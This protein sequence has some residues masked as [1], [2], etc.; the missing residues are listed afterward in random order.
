MKADFPVPLKSDPV[1]QAG[2]RILAPAGIDAAR[3]QL[4]RCAQ[5]T[6][7]PEG[8]MA[9]DPLDAGRGVSGRNHTRQGPL[10]AARTT[11]AP[12][13]YPKLTGNRCQCTACGEY[14]NGLTGFDCHRIGEHGVDHRC[15]T[16]AEMTGKGW[17]KSSASFW[18]TDSHAQRAARQPAAGVQGAR[19]VDPLPTPYPNREGA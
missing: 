15:M 2:A 3:E 13:N 7:R 11:L 1:K 18:I 17:C 6:D 10:D 4:F 12:P 5:A 8:D 9:A 14:F 16:V 19:M